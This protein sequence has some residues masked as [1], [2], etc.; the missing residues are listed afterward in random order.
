MT[1]N[2]DVHEVRRLALKEIGEERLR[3]A[4]DAEKLRIRTYRS[5]WSRLLAWLP[6]TITWKT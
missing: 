2:T 5:P 3:E 4:I 1:L 6:F